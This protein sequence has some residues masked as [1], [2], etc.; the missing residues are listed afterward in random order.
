MAMKEYNLE[1]FEKYYKDTTEYIGYIKK[2]VND[3]KLIGR[4]DVALK[5]LEEQYNEVLFAKPG[6]VLELE[7]MR[8]NIK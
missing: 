5:K 6:T 8:I 7:N 2:N 3:E 1:E 4:C